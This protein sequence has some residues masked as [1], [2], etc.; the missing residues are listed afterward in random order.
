MELVSLFGGDVIKS[1]KELPLTYKVTPKL[2]EGIAS[3]V[4]RLKQIT[5]PKEQR[6][7]IQSLE[8]D[9]QVCLCWWLLLE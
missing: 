8:K 1:S 4:K 6:N 2:F 9:L 7:F 5:K 3:A